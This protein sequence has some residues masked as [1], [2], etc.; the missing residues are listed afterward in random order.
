LAEHDVPPKK[1]EETQPHLQ[2]NNLNNDDDAAAT[3][4]TTTTKASTSSSCKADFFDDS[5]QEAARLRQEAAALALEETLDW[6]DGEGGISDTVTLQPSSSTGSCLDLLPS[7]T[8][9]E[10]LDVTSGLESHPA[11]RQF[12]R[13]AIYDATNSTKERRS[14]ILTECAKR[15]ERNAAAA[16]ATSASQN[17]SSN[18]RIGVLFLES[19][20]DDPELLAE[21]FRVKISSCPDFDGMTQ[22]EALQDLQTRIQKYESRYETIDEQAHKSYIKIFNLSSRL[23]VNHVYG[24]LAKVVLPAIMAWNTGSRPIFLCVRERKRQKYKSSCA[25]KNGF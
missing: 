10:D 19:I 16:A 25:E 18:K 15:T 5:N 14:W 24:R 9:V 6:L 22:E 3:T 1:E 4:T 13:I 7:T 12:H 11:R 2:Q 23:M 8:A 20:C 17:S 21:N